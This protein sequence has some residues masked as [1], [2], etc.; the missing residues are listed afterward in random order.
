MDKKLTIGLIRGAVVLTGGGELLSS[1]E[2][3]LPLM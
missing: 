1:A 3:L 2:D